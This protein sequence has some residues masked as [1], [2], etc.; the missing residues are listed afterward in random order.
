MAQLVLVLPSSA[1]ASATGANSITSPDTG[2]DV[3]HYTSLALDASGFPVVSYYD[4]TNFD[5]KVMHCDDADCAGGNDSITSPD[6]GGSVGWYTSLALDASGY[7]VVS[8][9]DCGSSL[10]CTVRDLKVLH[11]GDANCTSGNSITSPDTG[12]AVGRYT[13]LALDASG[14][15]VVSYYDDTNFDLKVMHCNDANCSAG[16]E[17]ITSPDTAGWAG[18]FTSLV[19]DASGFP[20]VSYF[21]YTN[22]ANGGLKVLHCGDANCTSGNSITS[23]DTGGSVGWHT[24]LE[25]DASGYPVVSY[26]DFTNGDLKVMHCDDADCAG[27]NDSITSP[28]T[29]GDVGLETS[30]ALDA[31]GYPVVSYYDVTNGDLKVLHCGNANCTSGNSITAP[32]TGGSVGLYTSLALDASG[33][34]VVS[35]YD[36]S[37]Y[38]STYDDLNVLHCGDANCTTKPT[39]TPTPQARPG[40]AN[41]DGRVDARDAAV[42]L[43]YSAGLSDLVLCL[44]DADA[45]GDGRVTALDALLVLHYVAD[46]IYSLPP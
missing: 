11:C 4:D 41:C 9:H 46:L 26:L 31:S 36:S 28:D 21:D 40:D 23:P 12:G 6:T 43:Q 32:D 17:S 42:I 45:D 22:D 39:P 33:Y 44:A 30:L 29:G 24:S 5:L 19:L 2:G 10:P 7:P 16:D 14:F 25:L 3:G 1:P 38:G 20:V 34:P 15:P 35:Y 27:G 37:R 13:S 18:L 8:Y